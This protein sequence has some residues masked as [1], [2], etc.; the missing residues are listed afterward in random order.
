MK[1]SKD[2]FNAHRQKILDESGKIL[3]ERG[4]AG[5][6]VNDV[7]QAAGLT[8]GAFYGHFKSKDDLIAATVAHVLGLSKDVI[9]FE[10]ISKYAEAYLTEDHRD[11]LATGC[12][13]AALSTE[14][15]RESPEVR[16]TLTEGVRQLLARFERTA[17]GST[18]K[19]RRRAAI[20][21]WSEMLGGLILARLVD[22]PALSKEILDENRANLAGDRAMVAQSSWSPIDD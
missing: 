9:P 10:T 1:V 11:R 4:V 17:P 15:V 12:Q 8:H 21:G 13:F 2:E 5:L 14:A 22:D 19:A 16:H 18:H 20:A 7:M 3:R 6:T